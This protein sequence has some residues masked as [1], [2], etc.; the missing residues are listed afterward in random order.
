[1]RLQF[2]PLIVSGMCSVHGDTITL[3]IDSEQEER[4]QA[5]AIF[6]ETLHAL[7]I[8]AGKTPEQQE[9]LH[10]WVEDRAQ[11]LAKRCPE[12]V[13]VLQEKRPN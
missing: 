9:V 7:L 4:E 8:A 11:D 1:M 3:L 13:A 2:R 5:V 6:H 10:D 12:I